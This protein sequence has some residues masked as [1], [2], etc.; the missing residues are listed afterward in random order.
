M[1]IW[2]CIKVTYE[3]SLI[4]NQTFSFTKKDGRYIMAFGKLEV[5]SILDVVIETETKK[6]YISTVSSACELLRSK[7]FIVNPALTHSRNTL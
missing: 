4:A 5:G 2:D 7:V 3:L 1:N 6:E